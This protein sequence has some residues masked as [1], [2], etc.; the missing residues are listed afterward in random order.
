MEEQSQSVT[1]RLIIE[2]LGSPADHIMNTLK[3]YVGKLKEEPTVEVLKEE[4]AEPQ[5]TEKGMFT[6]F[7][8]LEMKF[9]DSNHLVAF[10][11][12]AMPSSVE[13]I[14]PEVLNMPAKEFEG[15]INDLQA[16]LHT[17]DLAIKKLKATTKVLDQNAVNT[18]RNFITFIL[19]QSDKTEKELSELIGVSEQHIKSFTD[20]MVEDKK[21][22]REGDKLSIA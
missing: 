3:N 16:R 4:Y 7:V 13:V 14:E 2:M 8:E 5:P 12:D 22:K 9:Q 19:K 15:L 20:K 17:V 21:I 6:V 18:F 10:C 1:A 11:F